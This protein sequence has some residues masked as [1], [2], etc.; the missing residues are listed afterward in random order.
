MKEKIKFS[1]RP[2]MQLLR[3]GY[4]VCGKMPKVT[5]SGNLFK[6]KENTTTTVRLELKWADIIHD[7]L[8]V[9]EVVDEVFFKNKKVYLFKH[10]FY[11][12]SFRQY[13]ASKVESLDNNYLIELI[14]MLLFLNP[15]PTMLLQS[16]IAECIL[17]KFT[18]RY[19]V[20]SKVKKGEFTTLPILE[21]EDVLILVEDM[22]KEKVQIWYRP[23]HE[24]NVMYGDQYF[25]REEKISLKSNLRSLNAQAFY[26][27]IITKAINVLIAKEP[28]VKIN[29][30]ALEKL[31]IIKKY[32]SEKYATVKLI[33]SNLSDEHK[34][35]ILT[36]NKKALFAKVE[37]KE[38]YELFN[39]MQSPTLDEV[40]K[41]CQISRTDA[42][43]FKKL[44]LA[45]SKH[46]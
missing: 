30:K 16:K 27:P 19:K 24:H 25:T 28:K 35:I 44:K 5:K 36:H 21:K 38:K 14:E 18:A 40:V 7:D 11:A 26:F 3:K 32:N 42:M 1:K 43:K 9:A 37:M 17:Q 10:L 2:L 8:L 34:T 46:I 45:L 41:H 23:L 20:K 22:A 6:I 12:P 15:N 39:L 29:F 31:E 4:E 33:R 13:Y